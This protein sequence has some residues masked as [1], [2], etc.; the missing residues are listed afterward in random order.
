VYLRGFETSYGAA[1]EQLKSGKSLDDNT[2]KDLGLD[3]LKGATST[4]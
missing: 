4:D 1:L 2:L 3:N